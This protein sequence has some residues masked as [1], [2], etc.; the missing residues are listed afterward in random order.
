MSARP[1][2]AALRSPAG[3]YAAYIVDVDGTLYYQPRLRRRMAAAILGFVARHPLRLKEIL[4]VLAYRKVHN[5]GT[6]AGEP[7]FAE[8]EFA[9]AGRKFGLTPEQ[10]K[11]LFRHWMLETPLE[12]VHRT[13]DTVLLAFLAA[14]KQRGAQ[15]I[16]YSD[17][18]VAD[19]LHC[20]GL[21]CDAG[22]CADDENIACLKP[23]PQGLR[24]ILAHHELDP[25]GCLYIGDR[26]EK[27]GLCAAACGLDFLLLPAS[28]KERR[29]LYRKL[30]LNGI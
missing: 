1:A 9:W 26:Y 10:V 30:G 11:Q 8:K 13:R 12:A 27:D 2:P 21:T 16:A 17:Y 23:D 24:R 28:E 6:F 20:L 14:Q 4:A 7:D 3:G 5:A 18:P 19:K 25:A 15:V 22:Y 29:A